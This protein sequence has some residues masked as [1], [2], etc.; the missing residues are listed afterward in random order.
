MPPA[1]PDS[2]LRA[3]EW[4]GYAGAVGSH[5]HKKYIRVRCQQLRQ[6]CLRALGIIDQT[7]VVDIHSASSHFG[8]EKVAFAVRFIQQSVKL[9]PIGFESD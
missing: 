6:H 7:E 5:M 4:Q 1:P 8:A 3:A 2:G 9:V